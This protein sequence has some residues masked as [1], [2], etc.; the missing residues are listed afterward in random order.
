MIMKTELKFR[1]WSKSKNRFTKY[2]NNSV[3]DDVYFNI[4]LYGDIV[5]IDRFG[6]E[7]DVAQEDFI[8]HRFTGLK[9]KNGKEIYEGDIILDPTTNGNDYKEVCQSITGE[10]Q[11]LYNTK[12]SVDGEFRYFDQLYSRS[13]Y[14][15]VVG[16]I[17]QNEELLKTE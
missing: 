2:V 15:E 4:S 11:I 1:V 16:N 17:F 10:W 6:S 12:D 3:G 7:V 9:D 8:I 14:S 13:E 5:A